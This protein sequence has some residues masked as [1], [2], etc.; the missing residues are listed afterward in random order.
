MVWAVSPEPRSRTGQRQLGERAATLAASYCRRRLGRDHAQAVWQMLADA[1]RLG[2]VRH[3]RPEAWAGGAV[4]ALARAGGLIRPHGPLNAQEVAEE[5]DVTLGALGVT[6]RE[7]ARALHVAR[8]AAP[9]R[10]V[11]GGSA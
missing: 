5:F 10:P 3:G 2:V 11:T 9:V 8:Y 1:T 6:E 7:L 4:I